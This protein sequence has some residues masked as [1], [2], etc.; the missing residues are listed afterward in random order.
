VPDGLVRFLQD[1]EPRTS[2]PC[3]YGTSREEGGVLGAWL[4]GERGFISPVECVLG[5]GSVVLKT[6][7]QGRVTC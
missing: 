2:L 7:T 6:P 3:H 1:G 4:E 5:R